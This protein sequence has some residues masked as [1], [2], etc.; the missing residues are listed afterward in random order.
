M[1]AQ[2]SE[3]ENETE[4]TNETRTGR[5]ISTH[6]TAENSLHLDKKDIDKS[7]NDSKEENILLYEKKSR[8]RIRDE[9][10]WKKKKAAFARERGKE[11]ISYK[12]EVVP[13][14]EVKLGLLCTEKCRLKCS[15]KFD[16]NSRREIHSRFYK[17]DVN[18]KN[19]LLFKSIELCTVERQRTN[20]K[21]HKTA[22]YKFKITC[23]TTSH[24]VC[25]SAFW[26]LYGIGRKKVDL[27]QKQIK[28]GNSAPSPDSRGKHGSRPHRIEKEVVD[29]VKSHIQSFPA[30]ESHYSRHKNPHKLFLSP[31]LNISTMYSLYL[32]KCEDDKKPQQYKIK[33]CSY[34]N[35]FSTFFNYS[36][37]LPRSDTCST[38]DSGKEDLEHKE[39]YEAAFQL[40]RLD[41][42]N[43]AENPDVL[44]I[45]V[46]LQ[47][48]MPLPRL[49]TSKAFYLRQMWFYNLGVHSISTSGE[50]GYFFTW[51]EDVAGRGSREVTS[52]L[53]TFIEFNEEFIKDKKHLIV[54]SDSCAGQNKNFQTICLY[55]YLVL[56]G[57]FSSIDHKFPEVG[58]SY[59][60]SD[61]DFGRIEKV[62][63][64]QETIYVPD[65]YRDIIRKASKKNHVTDMSN[66]FRDIDNLQLQLKLVQKK[67]N[68]LNEKIAFR[69]GIKWLR[70]EE[71]GSYLYKENYDP[72]TP[73][74]TVSI[75]QNENRRP[76]SEDVQLRRVNEKTGKL[77]QKKILNLRD[78]MPYVKEEYRWFY[79]EILGHAEAEVNKRRRTT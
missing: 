46:D 65:Q 12:G 23:N 16:A 59:L 54:W 9:K 22:S 64:K 69:D 25:K 49:T 38:C 32:E 62:L 72:C 34:T 10:N 4:N 21:S 39:N 20:A 35:I 18:A 55:Q 30:E 13:A 7:Q 42:K 68:L 56:K 17:L 11:Y 26:S 24:Q 75:L 61:R 36:F 63:R 19:S 66:H 41:R 51:T 76:H 60:D 71:F 50:K 29:F 52:A 47:Q 48:T 73:F 14:K 67:K 74:K 57:F 70:V 78:Q 5:M 53:C 3:K 31:A 43:A 44:Y 37:G 6:V 79:N 8:K 1:K 45:T 15:Q 28:M 40:Q 77:S 2:A 58:H 27:I 33:K